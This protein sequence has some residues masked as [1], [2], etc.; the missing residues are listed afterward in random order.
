MTNGI[1]QYVLFHYY[2]FN[3]PSKMPFTVITNI[4]RPKFL[5]EQVNF[6]FYLYQMITYFFQIYWF[7]YVFA[8]N[9]LNYIFYFASTNPLPY[10]YQFSTSHLL[11]KC[12]LCCNK[13]ALLSDKGS[14]FCNKC[15]CTAPQVHYLFPTWEQFIPSVGMWCSQRGNITLFSNNRLSVHP[16]RIVVVKISRGLVEDR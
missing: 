3:M 12:S 9:F 6:K 7:Y 11:Q 15:L 10:L 4:L 5:T 8:N 1:L 14:L 2:F 16:S 13:R